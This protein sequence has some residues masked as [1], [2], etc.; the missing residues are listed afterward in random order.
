MSANNQILIVG[1]GIGGL[2][3]GQI[4]KANNIPFE[5]FERDEALQSRSQGWAI[6]LNEYDLT[7]R[8]LA[9][10]YWDAVA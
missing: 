8:D 9:A 2:A 4:L 1:A 3:L 5:I 6:A 7:C 10:T